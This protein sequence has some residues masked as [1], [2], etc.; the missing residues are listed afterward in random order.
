MLVKGNRKGMQNKLL[1][2]FGVIIVI[3]VFLF[4]AYLFFTPANNMNDI[5]KELQRAVINNDIDKV[6]SILSKNSINLNDEDLFIDLPL[7]VAVD[8]E[9]EQMIDLLIEKGA[10]INKQIVNS[11]SNV[12]E[13]AILN[14]PEMIGKLIDK[15]YNI[16]TVNSRGD[17]ALVFVLK[18]NND[19]NI[20]KTLIEHG[21]DK[22]FTDTYGKNYL[23][24]A[25]ESG[26]ID[27]YEYLLKII[28]EEEHKK[29]IDDESV[30][31]FAS[32][33]GNIEFF[34][35]ILNRGFNVNEK[36][37]YGRT[38]L[39]FCKSEAICNFLLEK[40]SFDVNEKDVQGR[41]PVFSVF[42]I[43]DKEERLKCL[44]LLIK[45]GADVKVQAT[46]GTSLLHEAA[47]AGDYD[48]AKLL[49]DNGIDVNVRD[50]QNSTALHVVASSN[51]IE[52]HPKVAKLLLDSGADK[53]IKNNNGQIPLD[54]A[55]SVNNKKIIDLLK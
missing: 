13:L 19:L 22:H 14:S 10:D 55:A 34:K 7:F 23:H 11:Y 54:I 3:G 53:T 27:V 40:F 16:N 12:L 38:V 33:S 29:T 50:S 4:M 26:D 20:I 41:T 47:F 44:S 15:G 2:V 8:K 48:C 5:Y 35:Y 43:Y 24:Y 42:Q 32:S 9:Y 1:K 51:N 28:P 25:A 21:I 17:N 45:K 31:H 36:D 37:K 52:E 46:D 18:F 6:D 49:I 30:I 39:H